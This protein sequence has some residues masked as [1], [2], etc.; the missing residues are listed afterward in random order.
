MRPENPCLNQH[1]NDWE[2]RTAVPLTAA[3]RGPGG[4]ETTAMSAWEGSK[5]NPPPLHSPPKSSEG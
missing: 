5:A 3:V 2:K 1:H 4:A